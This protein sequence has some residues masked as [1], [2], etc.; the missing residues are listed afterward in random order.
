MNLTIGGIIR[1]GAM[2]PYPSRKMVRKSQNHGFPD[3]SSDY[4]D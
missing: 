1:W 2:P 4:H 3:D